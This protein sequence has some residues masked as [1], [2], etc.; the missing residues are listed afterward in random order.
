M[1]VFL[2]W[3]GPTSREV[4]FALHGWLPYVIQVV[5]PFMSEDD[6]E[7]GRLWNEELERELKE[8]SHGIICVT[9]ENYEKPW[10][11]FEAGAV[12]K[13][14]DDASEVFLFLFNVEPRAV[15]GP[16]KSFQS[17]SYEK[18]GEDIFK[19]LQAINNSLEGDERVLPDV[20]RKEFETWWPRLLEKLEAIE[21]VPPPPVYPW[22]YTTCGLAAELG[23]NRTNVEYWVVSTNVFRNVRTADVERAIQR[24]IEGGIH[25]LFLIPDDDRIDF[26][27]A[28]LYKFAP[29]DSGKIEVRK[30]QKEKFSSLAVSDCVIQNPH[31]NAVRVFVELPVSG[32][33]SYWIVPNEE[34]TQG[35]VTRFESLKNESVL[36]SPQRHE[37]H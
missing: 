30:L 14:M 31:S 9:K 35:F 12:L 29:P 21:D 18:T 13:A 24:D 33:Q 10:I 36:V 6:I 37:A 32:E 2:S 25:Y 23:R 5:R 4:A 22:L 11:N 19:L 34:A 3:S 26:A 8:A 1:K 17:T 27:V 16:L 20:L 15:Q 28:S 7:K